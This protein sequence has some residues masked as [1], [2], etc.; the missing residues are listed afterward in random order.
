MKLKF[1]YIL[2]AVSLLGTSCKDVLDTNPTNAVAESEIY[3]TT[4]NVETVINGTWKYLNDTYF[5]FANPGYTA[6]LRTSDAMGSDVALTTKYGYRDAYTFSELNNNRSYRAT[7]FWTLLYKVIDNANNVVAKVDGAEGRTED[8]NRLKGQAKALRAFA[9]LNL[10]SFYQFSYQKDKNALTVPIYTEPSTVETKGNPRVTLEKLYDQIL[11]DLKDSYPLLTGYAGKKYKINQDVVQG[12]LAR[13]YLQIGEWKLAAEAAE[14]L[15]NKYVL[16]DSA[17]YQEGFN[18]LK[19]PEWIWGHEQ[20]TEQNTAS[21]TFHYLDVSSAASYYFSFMA[22]PYF[23]N[24]FDENDVRYSL[25]EWDP[26]TGREGL[27]RYKKFKFKPNVIGDIVY[28]RS[29]EMILIEAEGYA[30]AGL[31]AES[32][33]ALNKLRTARK[34]KLYDVSQGKN[35]IEEILIERRKELWGE[36]FALSDIIRTQGKVQRKLYIDETGKPIQVPIK[37]ANG[38]TKLVNGQGHRVVKF[39]DGSNFVAN[40]PYYLFAVPNEEIVRNPN[41]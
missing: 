16:M 10:A 30:R 28:M 7:S 34:A 39:P 41:L 13:T 19:N 29:S 24:L 21:Y 27:L 11:I 20:T 33:A 6:I 2:L 4:A 25:F 40:S 9:Y 12:L 15:G 22:D 5:T 37:T 23:K 1:T 17:T 38:G 3:K 32:I 8:K 35:L 36:G 31:Q 26:L 14:K 18:D